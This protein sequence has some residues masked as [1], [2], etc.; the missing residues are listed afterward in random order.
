MGILKRKPDLPKRRYASDVNDTSSSPHVFKRNRTLTGTTSN[1][2]SSVGVD[3]DLKSPR[4]HAHDLSIQRRKIGGIFIFVLLIVASIWILVAN[5]TASIKITVANTDITKAV[6]ESK[7]ANVIQDYMNTSPFSR[8]AFFLDRDSLSSYVSSKLPEVSKISLMGSEGMG[9]SNFMLTLRKPVASWQINDKQYYVDSSGIPFTTSYF[10]STGVRIVDNSGISIKVGTTAIVSNRF[11]GFVGRVVSM[12][13]ASGYNVTQAALPADTT[14]V[15]EVR[16]KE[17]SYP[18][19]F[20]IDRPA[21]EQVEDM[22]AAVNYLKKHGIVPGYVDVRVSGK[23][24][25]K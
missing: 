10:L 25:Y 8:I 3:S 5:F 16:L 14:R 18:I 1:H 12:T 22:V 15:L 24:F 11:L 17:A 13:R 9:R 20:T 7:Y 6:D 4:A 21:G 19:K 2:L 23:A